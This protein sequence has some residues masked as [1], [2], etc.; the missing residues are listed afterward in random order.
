MA[1]RLYQKHPSHRVKSIPLHW[2]D[3]VMSKR[4][5]GLEAVW[6]WEEVMVLTLRL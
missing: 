6:E 1:V 2:E 4:A 3:E 5:W